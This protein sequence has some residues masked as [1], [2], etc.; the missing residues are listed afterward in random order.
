VI[1]VAPDK[2]GA[3]SLLCAVSVL[4]ALP[5]R[6]AR[7]QATGA[8]RKAGLIDVDQRLFFLFGL[9]TAFEEVLASRA[10]LGFEG[11]GVQQRFFYD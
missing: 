1:A 7:P 9:I 10:M 5:D 2:T 6:R 3:G 11:L 8:R 4:H